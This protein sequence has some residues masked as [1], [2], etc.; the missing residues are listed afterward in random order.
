MRIIPIGDRE[1][2]D[3]VALLFE[4][5]S[6]SLEIISK[7]PEYFSDRKFLDSCFK[8]KGNNAHFYLLV[9]NGN[10]N[11]II[12]RFYSLLKKYD[13]VSWWTVGHKK[14]YLRRKK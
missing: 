13:S 8:Q 2:P 9:N 11:G 10:I 1:E 5:D 7:D 3:G 6:L 12:K 14:F 4:I